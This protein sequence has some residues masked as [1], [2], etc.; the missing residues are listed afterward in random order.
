M[1]GS[2]PPASDTGTG[3]ARE[4]LSL[5]VVVA[6]VPRGQSGARGITLSLLVH[7]AVLLIV[8]AALRDRSPASG[9]TTESA[10]P[11]RTP[12][13]FANPGGGD[14]GGG[15]EDKPRPATS[16]QT[17]GSTVRAISTV[18]AMAADVPSPR[19]DPQPDPPPRLTL[20]D[21]PIEAGLR[22]TIGTLA[23]RPSEIAS[24]GL[25]DGPGADGGRGPGIGRRG[26]SGIGDGDR[27]GAGGGDGEEPGNGVSWPRLLQEVKPN[28]TA[29]AMRARVEGLVT[30]EIVVLPDG[31]VGRISIVRSLDD[32]FGL[33]EEAIKAV[34]HWR[35]DP[36]RRFGKAVAVKVPVELFFN[37]R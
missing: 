27:P 16:A 1:A 6:G 17:T 37:L 28:Y 19:P 13:F 20:P 35:F 12:V 22:D 10:L 5:G 7:A 9:T 36:G 2:S 4:Q 32:R 18:P 11:A 30:L 8:S 31:S 3:A 21:Q 33:D 26:G 34:R 29:E 15:G 24:R 23:D 25:G 14:R